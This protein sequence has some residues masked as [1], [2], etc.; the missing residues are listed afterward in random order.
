MDESI[1]EIYQ[2]SSFQLEGDLDLYGVN[3][4]VKCCPLGREE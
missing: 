3:S 4:V 2:D 1:S